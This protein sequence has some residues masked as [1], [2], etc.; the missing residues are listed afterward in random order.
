VS[1][2]VI[3]RPLGIFTR[4]LA[5]L[6]FELGPEMLV[7]EAGRESNLGLEFETWTLED[8]WVDAGWPWYE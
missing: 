1:I 8:G 5:F 3:E 7:G 4:P 6:F 2:R